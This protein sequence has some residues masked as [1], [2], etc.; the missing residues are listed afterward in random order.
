[1]SQQ[2]LENASNR[3]FCQSVALKDYPKISE[4]KIDTEL[5]TFERI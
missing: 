5:K 4:D 3:F 2:R 1:M